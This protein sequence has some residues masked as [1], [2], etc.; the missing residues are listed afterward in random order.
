MATVMNL[1][2]REMGLQTS[3]RLLGCS[4]RGVGCGEDAHRVEVDFHHL[5]EV[6]SL[7]HG[8]R[9]LGEAVAQLHVVAVLCLRRVRRLG[10]HTGGAPRM[11]VGL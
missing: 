3:P 5:A 2:T 9:E 1:C 8:L 11:E 7:A 10:L 6:R 4:L